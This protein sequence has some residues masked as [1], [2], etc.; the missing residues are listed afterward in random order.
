M[1]QGTKHFLGIGIEKYADKKISRLPNALRDVK[2]VAQ[3][4]CDRYDFN[5]DNV[6]ILKN[7][8]LERLNILNVLNA[9]SKSKKVSG[10]DSLLIYFAGHC[11]LD[12]KIGYW[13]PKDANVNVTVGTCISNSTIFDEISKIKCKHVLLI[14]DTC[15]ST[16]IIPEDD[17]TSRDAITDLPDL[18]E[19]PND[20]WG[21]LQWKESRCAIT[22]AGRYEK[23]LDGTGNH[24]PFAEA[25]LAA[26][27]N[28]EEPK[29]SF[30]HDVFPLIQKAMRGENQMPRAGILH[31][32]GDGEGAFVVHLKQEF[33]KGHS[34][35]LTF[36]QSTIK[37]LF[38]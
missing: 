3:T 27:R 15:F 21:K 11:V 22:S 14:S 30:I 16:S 34:L 36:L 20:F 38:K 8:Q 12:G 5:F 29:M 17:V 2:A 25:L 13:M 26:L 24:S 10:E 32:L 19:M 18:P 23:A 6:K 31:G 9:Y 35:N 7:E 1:T 4:L 37:D 28:N 33:Q